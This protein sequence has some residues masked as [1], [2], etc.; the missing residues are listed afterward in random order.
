MIFHC[1]HGKYSCPTS[2][3]ENWKLIQIQILLWRDIFAHV[4][5]SNWTTNVHKYA[6]LCFKFLECHSFKDIEWECEIPHKTIMDFKTPLTLT[7]LFSSRNYGNFDNSAVIIYT[8]ALN[9]LPVK[10]PHTQE[11]HQEYQLHSWLISRQRAVGSQS[12]PQGDIPVLA[13]NPAHA[14]LLWAA[15]GAQYTQP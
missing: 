6:M 12:A 2:V 7:A 4:R 15:L 5:V 14:V 11:L 3:L 9:Q 8:S 10:L 13:P 1:I